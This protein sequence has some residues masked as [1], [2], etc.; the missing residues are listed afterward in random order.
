MPTG[1]GVNMRICTC[2]YKQCNTEWLDNIAIAESASP[3]AQL[4]RS[5][6][7]GNANNKLNSRN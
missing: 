1:I 7:T 5:H 3:I 6:P 4:D 2:G